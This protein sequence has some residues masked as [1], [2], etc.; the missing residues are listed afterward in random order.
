MIPDDMLD[1]LSVQTQVDHKV[2]K[3]R[4]NIIFKLLI[5]GLLTN[6]QASLRVLESVFNS[7]KFKASVGLNEKDR[8]RFNSIRDRIATIRSEYFKMLFEFCLER[9]SKQL[10]NSNKH[11][12]RYDSTMVAISARLLNIGFKAGD[13]TTKKQVKFT[14]GFDGLLPRSGKV[15]TEKEHTSEER[16]L[17]KLILEDIQGPDDIVVFDR[18]VQK[19]ST[20]RGLNDKNVSFVGRLNV[21]AKAKTINQNLIPLTDNSDKSL[22]I[23]EDNIV[24]LYSSGDIVECPFRLIK[25]RIHKT[26]KPIWFLTNITELDAY[27]IAD[28]YKRR[29]DIEVFFKFLK[30][31]LNLD[32]IL[33]RTVNG[34]EVTLYVTLT[35]AILLMAYKELNGLTGYK[36]TKLKFA[37]DLEEELI[38][39]I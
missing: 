19:R 27:E 37:L 15:F 13:K 31:E 33:V 14:I 8:T 23:E 36:I 32:H 18:G 29:W 26:Q 28:I 12:L 7:Y 10:H 3:L 4:G 25:G 35:A 21:G 20:Y 22:T 2:H 39:E 1:F 6:R 24:F 38:K 17:G 11:I 34:L 16:T 9:F 30:Q 5:Y